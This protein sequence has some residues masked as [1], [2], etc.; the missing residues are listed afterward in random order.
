MTGK[1]REHE[2]H[3]AAFNALAK[4]VAPDDFWAQ[5]QRTINGRVVDEA[6]IQMI[7]EAV[8]RGLQLGP[9][10]TLLDLCCGN[11]ALTDRVFAHCSGGKGVDVSDELIAVACR[12][13]AAPHRDYV[14]ADVGDYVR[15]EPSPEVY[16]KAMCYGSLQLL[17]A[18]RVQALLATLR[19]RYK[20]V[21]RVLIGN[22]PDRARAAEFYAERPYEP[23]EEFDHLR[24]LGAWRTEDE[25]RELALTAGWDVEIKRMAQD[26]YAAHYRFDAILTPRDQG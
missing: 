1:E 24:P 13:F 5:V 17:S 4:R 20:N 9:T 16:T 3:R 14:R 26:F 2:A 25:I 15:Q 11:G 7:V 10:D 8:V 23:G 19:K 21:Q 22:H 12:Y 18:Q 6:Q